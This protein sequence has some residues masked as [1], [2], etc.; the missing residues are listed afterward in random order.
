[1]TDLYFFIK[2]MARNRLWLVA[3]GLLSL[4]TMLCQVGLIGVSGW[5]ITSSAVVGSAAFVGAVAPATVLR[6]FASGRILGRYAERLIT[7]EAIFRSLTEIRVWLFARLIPLSP[8]RL[9]VERSG[10]LLSRITRD[11]D[12]LDGLYLNVLVPGAVALVA[13]ACLGI[14]LGFI[15]PLLALGVVLA[16]GLA[17]LGLPILAHR[18]AKHLVGQSKRTSEEL[19]SSLIDLSGGLTELRVYGQVDA[20]VGRC[21]RLSSSPHAT[22][23]KVVGV[24]AIA[25]SLGTVSMQLALCLTLI[26]AITLAGAGTIPAPLAVVMVVA[27]FVAFEAIVPLAPGFEALLGARAAAKDLRAMT[28]ASPPIAAASAP[29]ALPKTSDL[30]FVDVAF[31]YPGTDTDVLKA[32]TL[33]IAPG[34]TVGL[35]GPSGAGKSTILALALRFLD[36]TSGTVRFGDT[37][38]PD[39]NADALRSRFG[40]LS[41]RTQIF[42]ATLRDNLRLAG[43][44]CSDHSLIGALHQAGLDTFFAGLPEGLDTYLGENG[45]LVSGGEARR[46]ALARLYLKDAPILLL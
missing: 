39:L 27:V 7:H 6:L 11:I 10:T 20:Q 44:T 37:P 18:S 30:S 24:R 42:S 46:I 5:M 34:D 15:S 8:G 9:D 16:F 23:G 43:P 12:A 45:V 17:G 38:Y 32:I 33:E 36:P 3:G 26:V 22:Q 25:A 14:F 19:R 21:A 29:R 1:M 13:T 31:R 40:Y 4:F 35:S 28:S 2:L 41:Q